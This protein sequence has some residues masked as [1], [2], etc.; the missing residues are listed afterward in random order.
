MSLIALK[1][2]E[3]FHLNFISHLHIIFSEFDLLKLVTVILGIYLFAC[4]EELS[5]NPK[6]IHLFERI[7]V[8]IKLHTLFIYY[9]GKITIS[10][11]TLMYYMCK[12]YE[13]ILVVSMKI[14]FY[15]Y[16]Y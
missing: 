3:I 2:R 16:F 1:C 15:M 7:A 5:Y 9:C 4:S 11:I 8:I 12:M 10:A 13:Y 6:C 14:E